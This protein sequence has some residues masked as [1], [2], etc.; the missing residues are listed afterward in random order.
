MQSSRPLS[1]QQPLCVYVWTV[2]LTG[3]VLDIDAMPLAE[4]LHKLGAG[5]TKS[6][7]KIDH[8]VGAEILVKMGQQVKK[9]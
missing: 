7:E 5:R 2:W 3:A 4:V 6:G 9:G 8:S 1:Q